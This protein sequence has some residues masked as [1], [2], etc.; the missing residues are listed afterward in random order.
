MWKISN[1][2][3]K[4]LIVTYSMARDKKHVGF[5]NDWRQR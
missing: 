4:K 1:L 3:E 5:K 2:E